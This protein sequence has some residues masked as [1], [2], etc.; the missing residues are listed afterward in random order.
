MA[1]AP[2][3]I[4][5]ADYETRKP[6][7]TAQ[8]I[9]S[10]KTS[11]FFYVKDHGI[12]QATIAAMHATGK[13]FFHQ[14]AQ[15]KDKLPKVIWEDVELVGYERNDV[16]DGTIREALFT[17]ADGYHPEMDAAWPKESLL[18]GFKEA[19]VSF[20]KLVPPIAKKI[21]GCLALGLGFPEGFF[22][23]TMD[24]RDPD[25]HTL[26]LFQYY[27]EMKGLR[28][29]GDTNRITAHTD[30][31]LITLLFNEPTSTGLEIAMGKDGK[32][33]T[34]D[35]TAGQ[36][37][38]DKWQP[39]P[40]IPGCIIVNI[41]D[42]MQYWSDGELLSNFHRVRCPRPDEHQGVTGD[43]YGCY[44]VDSWTPCPPIPGCFTV[45]IGDPLQYWSN[46]VLP[47]NYHRVRCPRPGEYQGDRYSMLASQMLRTRVAPGVLRYHVQPAEPSF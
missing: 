21:V 11:G 39:S 22:E 33:V 44:Q 17:K 40:P 7:I 37:M 25:N 43:T 13:R 27:N 24:E 6:E 35:T 32:A 19:M 34:S 5:L 2:L 4:S 36:S 1:K 23:K 12:P 3:I 18:P 20:Q 45:N 16:A 47:S 28:V 15:E 9:E 30:E 38:V 8:L 29:K 41:G 46:G 31:T 14:P 26:M 10:A 42:T